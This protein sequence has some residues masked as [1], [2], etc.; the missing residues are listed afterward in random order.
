MDST[1]DSSDAVIFFFLFVFI[2]WIFFVF[3]L[4]FGFQ[5]T[6][7]TAYSLVRIIIRCL[8]Y[9]TKCVLKKVWN[10]TMDL[11]VSATT[12]TKVT[13]VTFV[14]TIS[15]ATPTEVVETSPQSE[16]SFVGGVLLIS[17]LVVLVTATVVPWL[18]TF[19]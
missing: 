8:F 9:I 3:S 13:T 18:S 15:V 19:T 10:T 1:M 16:P 12:K 14:T 6:C 5:S 4:N 2:A 11:F 7:N 17:G